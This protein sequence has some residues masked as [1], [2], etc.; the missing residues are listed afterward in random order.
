LVHVHAI[1]EALDDNNR[2]AVGRSPVQIE[3]HKRLP[4]SWRKPILRVRL[5]DR[6][7]GIGDQNAI[8]IV[9]WYDDAPGHGALSG[10]HKRP[11]YKGNRESGRG[12]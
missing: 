12:N 10:A 2:F 6:S 4:E 5:V 7:A 9:N 8:L 3:E 11:S 1:E